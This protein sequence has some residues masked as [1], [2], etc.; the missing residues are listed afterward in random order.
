M[1]RAIAA[2]AAAAGEVRGGFRRDNFARVSPDD[3]KRALT[4]RP[5]RLRAAAGPRTPRTAA[6]R[7]LL[8]RLHLRAAHSQ[9]SNRGAGSRPNA[10]RKSTGSGASDAAPQCVAARFARQP[11]KA[12]VTLRA[13]SGDGLPMFAIACSEHLAALLLPRRRRVA[14][15]RRARRVLHEAKR[16]RA[17]VARCHP[18]PDFEKTSPAVA[19]AAARAR[20]R[21]DGRGRVAQVEQ[22]G[23]DRS[24][25]RRQEAGRPAPRE[26]GRA[27]AAGRFRR[28]RCLRR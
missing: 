28:R 17:A 22:N 11:S 18:Q 1:D 16:R 8:R 5:G 23:V 26:R 3:R 20:R 4:P 19:A 10:S 21:G 9:P 13:A 6:Q 27:W 14:A 15:L 2:C 24:A 7:R 12:S 25:R